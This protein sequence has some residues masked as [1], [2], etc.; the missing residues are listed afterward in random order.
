MIAQGQHYDVMDWSDYQSKKSIS[1]SKHDVCGNAIQKW[2]NVV[3][4]R[5]CFKNHGCNY[6]F[7]R[8]SELAKKISFD[9]QTIIIFER[10]RN[11]YSTNGNVSFAN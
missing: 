1:T 3:N 5:M 4:F 11:R 2:L 7:Q 9:N 6:F 8:I 10:Q